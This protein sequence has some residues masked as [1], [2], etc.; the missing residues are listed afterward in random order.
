MLHRQVSLRGG[1][2]HVALLANTVDLL[3]HLHVKTAH[4]MEMSLKRFHTIFSPRGSVQA[5]K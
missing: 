1:G 3:V 5:Y 2:S 4:H